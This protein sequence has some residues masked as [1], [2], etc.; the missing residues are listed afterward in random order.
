MHNRVF[1]STI[2]TL[3]LF[4]VVGLVAALA[5]SI[6]PLNLAR[7]HSPGSATLTALTVTAGGTAQTLS[8][9]FSSTVTDYTVHVENS[10]A[11]VTIAGT[12]DGDG[13]VTYQDTDA[14]SGTDGHQVN[15][16]TLG[17]KLINVVVTHT[18]SG[19][20]ATQTYTVLVIRE[21]TVATDRAALMA[22]YNSTGGADWTNNTNWGST[23]P[24]DMWHGVYTNADGRVTQL[25]LWGNNLD[26]ILPA[27]LGNLDQ[28]IQLY[29]W[30]NQLSEAIPTSLGSLTNL[31]E[32]DLSNNRLTGSIPDELGSLTN[33][34]ELSLGYN[35][36]FRGDGGLSGTIPASLGNLTNLQELDLSNNRLTGSIPDELGSLT[37]L[38]ELSLDYNRKFRGDGGL[39]GT[40]PASLGNLTNLQELDLS[41]NRLTGSIPD[42]LGSLTNLQEL[43]LDYNRN[44][45]G[46]GGLSGTILA[47]LGNL[48]KL[49]RLYLDNNQLTGE[50]PEELGNLAS[51]QYLRLGSNQLTG[52]IP[53]ELGNLASLQSL[54]LYNNQLTGEIPA[55]LGNLTSLSVL[56]LYNN[57]LTGEIPEELG[58]LT[59]LSVLYLYNN[60]LTGEIPE[61]LGNLA[62]LVNLY[63]QENQL[64]GEIPEELG[65][66]ASLVILDLDNNQLT[67]E[68]P[69][70]LGNLASLV[71]LYLGNNQLTGEIPEELGNL[72]SLRLLYLYNNQLTGAIPEELGN[73][74]SLQHLYLDNNQLTGEIPEELGNL[75]RLRFLH[76]DNNQLTGEIPEELGN[77]NHLFVARFAGNALTGCVPNGLRRLMAA[78]D[79]DRLPAQDFIA[80]D[81]NGDGDTSDDGDT[82]GLGLP[83]CTLRWLTLSGVTLAPA[84]ASDTVAYTASATLDV[85]STTVMVGLYNNS[86]TVAITKGADTY[87]SGD[88]VPLEVGTNVITISV[89]TMDDTPS[90]HT[91]T[92]TVTRAPNTPPTFS[93]GLT[94][95]RGVEENTAA[96][97]NIGEPV[98][99]TDADSD[100]LTYSLDATSAAS[101]D[102]SSTTGQL[103]TK[104]ALDFEDKSSYTVTVSVRDSKDSNGDADEVTDDTITVTIQVA[105]LNEAPVF[106]TSETGMRS[107]YENTGA[108]MNIGAPVAATDD[109]ND[110]LTYSLDVTS[111][112]TFDIVATTGQLQ[113]KAALDYETGTISYTVTVTAVDPSGADDTITVTITV[114]NVDEP[115]TVTLSSTQPIEGTPLTA[116]LDDPD[117]VSGSATWSWA[118]SPNG[119]SSW[120]LISGAT[121]ASY[122]PVPADVGRYL[123]VTTSYT[124]GEGSGKSAQGVSA[125]RVQPAPVAPNEPPVFLT[126]TTLRNVDE[127]TVAGVNIGDPVAATD[128][129]SDTLTYSLDATSAASFDIDAASGQLRTKAALNFETTPSY[130]VTVTATDTGAATDTIIITITVNNLEE[131]GTVTLSSLQPQ[132]ATQLTAT[133]ADPD[134]VSGS[135]TWLWERSPDG[136][137][138]WTPISGATTDS[139]TP[140]FDD[141]GDYL[142]ATASYIDGEGGGKSAQAFSANAVEVALGRNK[143]VLREYPT[144]TRSVPRN[145]PA[146][147]NIGAPVS[148]TDADN[149]ALTY[150]L[151]G[152]DGAD[153]ALNTSSGQLLTKALLTGIQR[154]RYI[155][156]VSV[157]DGKDDLGEP[158]TDPQIDTSTEVT[159]NVTTTSSGSSGGGSG[160]SGGGGGGGGG[161][162]SGR[163]TPTPT[164]TPSPTPTATPT[165]TG[166]QFSGQIAAE[167]SVTA[168]VVPDGTPWALTAVETCQAAST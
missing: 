130:S 66:L 78:T 89:T 70:E 93:D 116:T 138:S 51:L 81:A 39:S 74:A 7:A 86:D 127:N 152:P 57:Q 34:Q 69:E 58:N 62:S 83:F 166:P 143:P 155:V 113:T 156:F 105:N 149:D 75:A 162:G 63:L 129:D 154:T 36:K 122:T 140:V 60:Q 10:V 32:L 167:P 35:R 50:I 97:M 3:A 5:P 139:Y 40:I 115:G 8:P 26:G 21:G 29:L 107:V 85:L 164:P 151:D 52:A 84:F 141:V 153:F 111:R 68:I 41:H 161:G 42:E 64:T 168:T 46:D 18:D 125:N 100:T 4:A 77:L 28:M 106:P 88:P 103:Q 22:L 48:T 31:Q 137:S 71:I 96:G 67:G 76:L 47:S 16:P 6:A 150:S 123:R 12:P 142:R 131:P 144:A 1:T 30:G 98:A 15:L 99:A 165:P 124:D 102:I 80:V 159:I 136:T 121:S 38:Q 148:A 95:T 114:N 25:N 9:A 128:A 14:D 55:E 45:R 33:L 59:S 157:S 94:T 87:M 120:T 72:A 163:A 27:A 119:T 43:S 112:A 109:D 134:D 44:F 2:A 92:V 13:T 146:G 79:L 49:T 145:T 61:E 118:R 147:R 19:T 23:E 24:L 73:L 91:Y 20:T 132:V 158:E 108:G 65:N 54:H 110:T 90:P 117:D 160:R 17:R 53:A 56:Y 11:Q 133:L 135:V 82:P 37:N 126:N 104:A 101:F